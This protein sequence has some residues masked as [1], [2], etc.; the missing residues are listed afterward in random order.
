LDY[1]LVYSRKSILR[2]VNTAGA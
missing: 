2:P 1:Q